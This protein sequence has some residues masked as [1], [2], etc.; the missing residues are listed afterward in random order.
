MIFRFIQISGRKETCM[1]TMIRPVLSSM[2]GVIKKTVIF[3]LLLCAAAAHTEGPAIAQGGPAKA[4][5]KK[6]A[7]YE[8]KDNQGAEISVNGEKIEFFPQSF[9]F[10][11]GYIYALNKYKPL[12]IKFKPGSAPEEVIKLSHGADKKFDARFFIDI[13][14]ADDGGFYLIEQSTA[15]IRKASAAGV[16]DKSYMITEKPLAAIKRAWKMP[17]SFFLIYDGGLNNA[18]IRDINHKSI[19]TAP[20]SAGSEFICETGSMIYS[21]LKLVMTDKVKGGFEALITPAGGSDDIKR[22]AFWEGAETVVALDADDEENFYFYALGKD[23]A[24]SIDSTGAKDGTL[25]SVPFEKIEFLSDAARN[26]VA[27]EPGKLLLLFSDGKKAYF[28][29]LTL[30]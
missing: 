10:S 23:G 18:Y 25:K 29:E 19:E 24:A 16:I 11:G 9:F 27:V 20:D 3:L 17:G 14:P 21:K 6:I 7:E 1:S 26:C 22:L 30:K 13:M 2:N 28:G 8:I 5:L 12:I 4:A 15:S